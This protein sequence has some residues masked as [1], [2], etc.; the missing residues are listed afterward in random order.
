M[1][2][3]PNPMAEVVQLPEHLAHSSPDGL[4]VA[5]AGASTSRG[6]EVIDVNISVDVSDG[7]YADSSDDDV[8]IPR[9]TRIAGAKTT[10]L[11]DGHFDDDLVDPQASPFSSPAVD[12]PS[13]PTDNEVSWYSFFERLKH[14]LEGN[15]INEGNHASVELCIFVEVGAAVCGMDPMK[16][17]KKERVYF[18]KYMSI[19]DE[20]EDDLFVGEGICINMCHKYKNAKKENTG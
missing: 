5:A 20:I 15:K 7:D 14:Y 12:D 18:Q 4:L 17:E 19:L 9:T 8:S 3:P 1:H 16:K 2:P 11:D 13:T 6:S 10:V